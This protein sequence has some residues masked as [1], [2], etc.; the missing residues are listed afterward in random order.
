[1]D[2]HL[3]NVEELISALARERGLDQRTRERSA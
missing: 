3:R 2:N 1:L